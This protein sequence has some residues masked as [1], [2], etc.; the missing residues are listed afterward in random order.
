MIQNGSHVT[1][2]YTLTVDGEV[3]DSSAGRE[4]LSYVHGQGQ[5]IPGLEE[6][7]AGL[8]SGQKVSVT[9]EPE[10]AYGPSHPEAIQQVPRAAF[11]DPDQLRPGDMVSGQMQ[12][13]QFQARV[14]EVGQEFITLDLNH[15]LAGKT[16]HFDV[17]I[18]EVA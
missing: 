1:F 15:P 5:I 11:R 10:K 18:L 9:V 12:G 2:H 8:E 16:L 14:T 4:P 17:E 7:L 13:Q 6:Q 3:I